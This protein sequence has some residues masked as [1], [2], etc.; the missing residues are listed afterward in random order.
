[1][2]KTVNINNFNCPEDLFNKMYN[3]IDLQIYEDIQT[4]MTL[5]LQEFLKKR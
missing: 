5:A 3:L 2:Q 4:V 1:M